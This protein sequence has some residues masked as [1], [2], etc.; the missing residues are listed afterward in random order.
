MQESKRSLRF[1]ENCYILYEQKMYQVAY[2]I[3]KD[4]GMAEDAVQEAFIKLMK[5]NK[6]FVDAES[7]D[8]KRYLIKIIKNASIT[9]YNKKKKEQELLYF[10]D[11]N[12]EF[13]R[14][15]SI[16]VYN[17]LDMD[18]EHIREAINRLPEKYYSVVNCLVIKN[19]TVKET[20][21]ALSIT[22]AN[23]RK[24]FER[25]KLLLK[26]ITKGIDSYEGYRVV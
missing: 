26:T 3:L 9:I 20:A 10:S 15:N 18:K 24:R 14:L 12:E 21:I 19:M 7:D 1:I 4:E 8:C 5:S 23:V 6:Y 13:E 11:S 16:E 2:R 17:V 22:E 25:S